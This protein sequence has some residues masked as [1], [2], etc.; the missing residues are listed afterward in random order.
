[1]AT[2]QDPLRADRK[3]AVDLQAEA[4]WYAHSGVYYSPSQSQSVRE[5]GRIWLNQVWSH[6]YI[7]EQILGGSTVPIL[8][9]MPQI[10]DIPDARRV[11][12]L[13][14]EAAARN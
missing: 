9:V 10:I 3:P 6:V 12:D 13:V 1:M 2:W 8:G 5:E 14:E 4:I 11:F 7:G